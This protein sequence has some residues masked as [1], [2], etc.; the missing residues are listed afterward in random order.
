MKKSF[1]ILLVPLLILL[2]QC[3]KE[4]V[5]NVTVIEGTVTE[6]GTRKPLSNVLVYVRKSSESNGWN[7]IW[8]LQDTVR[9]DK[10]GRY[11]IQFLYDFPS[12]YEAAIVRPPSYEGFSGGVALY[13]GKTTTY[14]F[15]LN[16]PGWLKLRVQNVHPVN[17]NDTLIIWGVGALDKYIHGIGVDSII[18][19]P[20]NLGNRFCRVNY[21]VAK[22]GS[23]RQLA[24]SVYCPA[25]DT[26]FIHIK[27]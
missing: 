16:P 14:D 22:N 9:T 13:Q 10:D 19:V 6:Y 11:R 8:T 25:Y 1:L 12:I 7:L 3:R 26:A 15:I 2:V 20:H 21:V 17:Q 18:Y 23:Q 27:Y 24:D 4:A 5:S